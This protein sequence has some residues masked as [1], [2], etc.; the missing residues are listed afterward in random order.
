MVQIKDF[1]V[2]FYGHACIVIT[3]KGMRIAIDPAN[4]PQYVKPVDL[5]L[6]TQSHHAHCSLKDIQKILKAQTPIL[7]PVD[8]PIRLTQIHPR[9]FRAVREGN[10]IIFG[11]VTLRVLAAHQKKQP[12]SRGVGYALKISDSV[13]YHAG[14]SDTKSDAAR[15]SDWLKKGY[16]LVG[17][18]SVSTQYAMSP[19]EAAM[20]AKNIETDIVLQIHYGIIESDAEAKQFLREC[21]ARTVMARMLP[22]EKS[23][24]I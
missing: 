1:D 20:F 9:H 14:D 4:L 8:V 24:K 16:F 18:V 7:C 11:P 15:L 10:E 5:I 6:V 3:Y 21:A 17:F 19:Q 2:D 22:M 12:E 23:S 13:V